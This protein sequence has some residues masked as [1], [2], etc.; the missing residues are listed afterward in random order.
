[1][2]EYGEQAYIDFNAECISEE[3]KK[4]LEWRNRNIARIALEQPH[5]EM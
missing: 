1:M 4:Y 2:N 3:E 5:E